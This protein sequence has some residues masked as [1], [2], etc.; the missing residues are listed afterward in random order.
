M[1]HESLV[2]VHYIAILY[3]NSLLFR[4]ENIFVQ[5]K[6]TKIFYVNIILQQ[7]FFRVGWFPATHKHFP[8]CPYILYTW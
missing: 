6:R 5:R 2:T 7:T 3:R 8:N 1:A 4:C